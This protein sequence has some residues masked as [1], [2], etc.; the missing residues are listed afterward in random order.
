MGLHLKAETRSGRTKSES[1]T[2]RAA[3][4]IPGIV[5]GK[6][7]ASALIAVD[8][9]EALAV[10]RSNPHAVVTMDVPGAGELPVMISEVQRDTLTGDVLHIDFHRIQMNQPVRTTVRAELVGEPQ[11]VREGG[12]MQVQTHEIEIK[13]LPDRIPQAVEVDVSGL[14][15]GDSLLVRDIRVPDGIEVKSDPTDVIVTILAP[16]KD[17]EEEAGAENEQPAAETGA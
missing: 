16:Q 12:I 1:K 3:G 15:M 9:R 17:K 4:K 14:E 11:G 2:L 7:M 5:Y 10:L 8:A 13:C 6:D